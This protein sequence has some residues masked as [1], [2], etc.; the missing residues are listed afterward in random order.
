MFLLVNIFSMNLSHQYL[1]TCLDRSQT[2]KTTTAA[3]DALCARILELHPYD[4]PEIVAVP[5]SGGSES[6]L[7]WLEQQVSVES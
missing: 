3:L 5:I 7:R 1:Y 6:Y 2:V 4:C